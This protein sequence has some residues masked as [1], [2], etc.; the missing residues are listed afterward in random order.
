MILHRGEV[1][2]VKLDPTEGKELQGQARP[3]I[4]VHRESLRN[5]GTAIIIPLTSQ[6]PK[7]GFPLTVA[8]SQSMGGTPRT[9]WAKITQIRVVSEDRIQGA[10]LG[11]LSE[12]ELEEI[13]E[14]LRQV[15]DL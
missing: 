13:K 6:E 12:N 5:V 7:A 10:R 3:C 11:Q 14:A 4:I 8:L 2:R 15:L 9:S 1:Y